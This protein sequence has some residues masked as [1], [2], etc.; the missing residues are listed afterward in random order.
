M[1]KTSAQNIFE[2]PPY[3]ASLVWST[4]QFAAL[5]KGRASW[6]HNMCHAEQ[7][8]RSNTYVSSMWSECSIEH[9]PQHH[10]CLDGAESD[11]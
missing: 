9:V 4:S 5:A 6:P 3:V 2:R 11:T 10:R 8:I 7:F 1:I